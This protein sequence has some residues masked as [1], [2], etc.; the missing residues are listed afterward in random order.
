V[1]AQQNNKNLRPHFFQERF[2]EGLVEAAMMVQGATE[3][4]LAR[5]ASSKKTCGSQCGTG[6]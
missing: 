3:D 6:I 4:R 5:L 1:S 2:G